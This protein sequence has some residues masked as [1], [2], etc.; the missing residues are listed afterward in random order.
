MDVSFQSDFYVYVV[1]ASDNADVIA[2]VEQR[3]YAAEDL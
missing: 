1:D 2:C 3:R